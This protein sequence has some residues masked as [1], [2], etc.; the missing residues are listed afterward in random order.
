MSLVTCSECGKQISDT[1]PYCIHC[2]APIEIALEKPS[3]EIAPKVE[4]M[5]AKGPA[6][7]RTSDP[8]RLENNVRLCENRDKVLSVDL[9]L[10]C[11]AKCFRRAFLLSAL[12]AVI[13]VGLMA[14]GYKVG[15]IVTVTSLLLQLIAGARRSLDINW[16]RWVSLAQLVPILG[17]IVVLM[18]MRKARA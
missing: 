17:L 8:D 5:E 2:G 1:A 14:A 7:V 15:V 9:G 12:L 4:V 16:T 18:F 10:P 6:I 11:S 3:T 13:G